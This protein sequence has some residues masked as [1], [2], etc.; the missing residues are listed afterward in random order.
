MPVRVPS[1]CAPNMDWR[2]LVLRFTHTWLH[3]CARWVTHLA[4]LPGLM[5]T[6]GIMP[7]YFV[8]LTTCYAST[9]TLWLYSTWSMGACHWSHLR[10]ATLSSILVQS[11]KWPDKKMEYG[12]GDL[13]LPGMSPKLS[14]T[15]QKHL[16][17][18]LNN[19]FCLPQRADNPFSSDYCPELDLSDPLDQEC[20]SFYQHLISVMRWMVELCRIDIVT[21]V[22]LLSSQLAYPCK[23]HLETALHMM[24]YLS[25]KHNTQLIFD[26]TYPKISMGQLSQFDWTKFYSD[27]EEAIPVDMPEPLGKDVDVRMMC[28]SDHAGDKMTRRSCTGFLISYNMA[29]IDWVFKKQAT[30]EM[31]VFGAKF[32]AMKHGTEMLWGL[33]YKLHMIGIPLTRPSFIYADN[34]SQVTNST[35]PELTLKKKCNSICYHVV[36]ESVAMGESLIT[37]IN[38]GENLS[39]L[40]TKVTR[41]SKHCQLVGNI[42]YDIYNDHPKQWGKTSRSRPTDLEGTEEIR[43]YLLYLLTTFILAERK[44][45]RKNT[46][47][48]HITRI[49]HAGQVV[50]LVLH[51]PRCHA[52]MLEMHTEITFPDL[53]QL[54]LALDL[55]IL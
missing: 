51:A 21:E 53:Q 26:P 40:M 32:V 6:L 15:V 46:F 13:A 55:L 1:L 50:L 11:W 8:M 9:T 16:T 49:L 4:K 52:C 14:R 42:L 45:C 12:H 47:C 20:S 35:R 22:S 38:S 7:T 44:E 33:W 54:L 17:D 10:L 48:E 37:Q 5:T 41:C 27:T 25:H 29:L 43:Q 19:H 36:R 23:G 30:V 2:V 18:K 28:D 39:D 34:K 24:S 3:S 31:S